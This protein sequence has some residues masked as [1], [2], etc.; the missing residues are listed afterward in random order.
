M[1]I[2]D[3]K[4]LAAE[5]QGAGYRA[6]AVYTTGVGDPDIDAG[7][8]LH[9]SAGPEPLWLQSRSEAVLAGYLPTLP[10]P[11]LTMSRS[12]AAELAHR[13]QLA[14]HDASFVTAPEPGTYQVGV[15]FKAT[16]NTSF[17]HNPGQAFELGLLPGMTQ[18]AAAALVAE[19]RALK[20]N[21][22]E[23]E[24]IGHAWYVKLPRPFTGAV[25][26]WANRAEAVL[27]GHLPPLPDTSTGY[28][29]ETEARWLA[30]ELQWSG[31][32]ATATSGD[33]PSGG[34]AWYAEATQNG[35]RRTIRSRAM[36]V[37]LKLLPAAPDE[38]YILLRQAGTTTYRDPAAFK[39]DTGFDLPG[40]KQTITGAS[41][42]PANFASW[43]RAAQQAFLDSRWSNGAPEGAS[44]TSPNRV[45]E[46]RRAVE[47]RLGLTTGFFEREYPAPD[48]G[49][50]QR[51]ADALA[52]RS[53]QVQALGL[54]IEG[55]GDLAPLV[56][57]I[58]APLPGAQPAYPRP[59]R[60]TPAEVDQ[61]IARIQA[62]I[63]PSDVYLHD[64]DVPVTVVGEPVLVR[65]DGTS[66]FTTAMTPS[67]AFVLE[68]IVGE[69]IVQD[70][71]WGVSE[72]GPEGWAL[73]IG[74]HAG[75]LQ[76]DALDWL[77]FSGHDSEGFGAMMQFYQRAIIVA[78]LAAAA[79]ETID[80]ATWL[81]GYTFFQF[82]NLPPEEY[83]RKMQAMAED[84][85]AEQQMADDYA[86]EQHRTN[87]GAGGTD[88]A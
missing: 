45:W 7:V 80:R 88:G 39:A 29:S 66:T 34:E 16:G 35:E 41:K 18:A 12:Q 14:G 37:S 44:T 49:L 42:L 58:E 1:N 25:H 52:L 79:C 56:A 24:Q 21:Q 11:P 59:A 32:D 2:S 83:A 4:N 65:R 51:A 78:S 71:Q 87:Y 31:I 72:H 62:H 28:L 75:R 54:A 38:T 77:N 63:G 46:A 84:A 53:A 85:S 5:L 8:E 70:E 86:D 74:K 55:E 43:D 48:T 76:A 36:A 68:Q 57:A 23:A 13:L 15:F 22:A 73:L 47:A 33:H 17:L 26:R 82:R 3:A 27:T 20:W 67:L 81:E 61:T 19:L 64:A 60:L 10:D 9:T 40:I 69:R 30:D 6:R 50:M